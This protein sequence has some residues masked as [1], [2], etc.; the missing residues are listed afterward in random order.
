MVV[1]DELRDAVYAV[2]ALEEGDDAF[3]HPASEQAIDSDRSTSDLVNDLVEE[4]VTFDKNQNPDRPS[5]FRPQDQMI[6]ALGTWV[7]FLG[8]YVE[9]FSQ[10]SAAERHSRGLSVIDE[11]IAPAIEHFGRL[12][13]ALNEAGFLEGR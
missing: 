3:T 9:E 1:D 10:Q 7:D 4:I 11:K 13:D 2:V 5:W 8:D 12:M 6:L